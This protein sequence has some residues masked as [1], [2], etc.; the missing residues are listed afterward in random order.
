MVIETQLANVDLDIY[1]RTNLEPLVEAFGKKVFVLYVGPFRRSYKAVLELSGNAQ[2]ADAKMLAFCRLI[3]ALP[4][5]ERTLWDG[6]SVRE[7]N[8]GLRG[9]MEPMTFE[10]TVSE[11]AVRAAAGVNARIGF[12]LYSPAM[13]A[14]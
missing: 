13:S 6:A 11:K 3:R 5:A 2:S 4:R 8:I 10:M 9:G 1:S 14:R 7:F 12:T